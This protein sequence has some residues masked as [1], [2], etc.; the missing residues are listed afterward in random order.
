MENCRALARALIATSGGG[1][2]GQVWWVYLDIRIK[3]WRY[4]GAKSLNRNDLRCARERAGVHD[5]YVISRVR[6]CE[7][8]R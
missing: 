3:D 6:A 5:V 2:C 7:S 1:V 8:W 4:W